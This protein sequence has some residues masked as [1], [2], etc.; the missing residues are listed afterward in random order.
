VWS[1]FIKPAIA[2]VRSDKYRVDSACSATVNRG[3]GAMA[4]AQN[5]NRSDCFKLF[6]QT[7][8]ESDEKSKDKKA[9]EQHQ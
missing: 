9:Q 6:H 8:D 2:L 1:R 3:G 5:W 7:K 4:D